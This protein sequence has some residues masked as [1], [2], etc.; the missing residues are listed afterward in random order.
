MSALERI[1]QRDGA[2]PLATA[3]G[4]RDGARVWLVAAAQQCFVGDVRQ[5]TAQ[6][7]ALSHEAASLSQC[8]T[9]QHHEQQQCHMCNV[10]MRR[11]ALLFGRS[12]LAW[13]EAY[14]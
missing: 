10:I 9:A 7:H 8:A 4:P 1:Q 14:E 11:A 6:A 5:R 13:G 12:A 3:T 2:A